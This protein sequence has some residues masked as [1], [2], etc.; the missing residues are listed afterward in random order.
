MSSILI[1]NYNRS[2]NLKSGIWNQHSD[3]WGNLGHTYYRL[4]TRHS[5]LVTTTG[6]NHVERAS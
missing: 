2:Q 5:L 3:P 1:R 6:G 4:V